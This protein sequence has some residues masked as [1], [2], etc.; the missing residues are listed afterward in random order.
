MVLGNKITNKKH[1][2]IKYLSTTN[3]NDW[4][5]LLGNS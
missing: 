5:K 3:S 4:E 2:G 1:V